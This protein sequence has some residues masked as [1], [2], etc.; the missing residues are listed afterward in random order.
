[1]WTWKTHGNRQLAQVRVR[2][3]TRTRERARRMDTCWEHGGSM[4]LRV[5]TLAKS[6]SH[7]ARSVVDVNRNELPTLELAFPGPGRDSVMAAIRSGQTG[8]PVFST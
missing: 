7:F 6:K 5:R 8:V 2:D 4:R 3:G 1:M